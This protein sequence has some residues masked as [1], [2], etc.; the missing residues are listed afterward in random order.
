MILSTAS[1]DFAYQRG[2]EPVIQDLTH[3]F[4]TG[5]VTAVT[6]PS[7]CGKSTLLYILA[8]ML[9]PMAGSVRYDGLEVSGLPD[10][11]RSRLRGETVGF[12]FQD[13]MLDP[14]RSVMDNVLEGSI[15][16][17]V[18]S[19]NEK[20]A[21]PLMARFGIEHRARHRPGEI[22][23]GQAQRVALCRA[24]L[25][26]PVIVLADE[27]TGNLDQASAAVVWS[28]LVEA[29]TKDGATVVVATHDPALAVSADHVLELRGPR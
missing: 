25:K 26:R 1:L 21:L 22:S 20:G 3:V 16:R 13:A 5:A 9:R 28:A 7:G 10:R 14:S 2:G 6:G 23:G 15:F 19:P 27:P 17:S 24:L 11:E 18:D 8:L 4:P 29:S 12:V